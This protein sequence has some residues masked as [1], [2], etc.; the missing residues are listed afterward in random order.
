MGY[1]FNSSK[2]N[3]GRICFIEKNPFW[4]SPL[5]FNNQ[6]LSTNRMK[7]LFVLTGELNKRDEN[8]SSF[9]SHLNETVTKKRHGFSM[10]IVVFCLSVSPNI[11]DTEACM[12]FVGIADYV[13]DFD[14]VDLNIDEVYFPLLCCSPCMDLYMLRV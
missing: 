1:F 2:I 9:M 12:E 7:T 8:T 3:N 14:T 13:V 5:F 10:P 4:N 11:A 6:V